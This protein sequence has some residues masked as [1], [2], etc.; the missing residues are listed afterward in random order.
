MPDDTKPNLRPSDERKE[1]TGPRRP[2][3]KDLRIYDA[4]LG[5]RVQHRDKLWKTA[6]RAMAHAAVLEE[7][8]QVI[9]ERSGR[10]YGELAEGAR[11]LARR[12]AL[13]LASLLDDSLTHGVKLGEIRDCLDDETERRRSHVVRVLEL[14][15][16]INAEFRIRRGE[17]PP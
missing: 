12:S 17:Y 2:T 7:T 14:V 15:C 8:P 11:R 4:E 13:D 3:P 10:R 5:S 16:D 1:G 9:D 6:L